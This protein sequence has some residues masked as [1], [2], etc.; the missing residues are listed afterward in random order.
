[1]IGIAQLLMA[2]D[3]PALGVITGQLEIAHVLADRA[4]AMRDRLG[5]SAAWPSSY[6]RSILAAAEGNVS[7]ARSLL[8]VART[9]EESCRV[10][11]TRADFLLVPAMAAA[12]DGRFA[13]CAGL[14]EVVRSNP[15]A[16]LSG[17]HF[18]I[19]RHLRDLAKAAL[20]PDEL[21]AAREAGRQIDT[22]TALADF[23]HPTQHA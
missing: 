18:A 15:I 12:H 16:L 23:L 3:N 2:G 19:A 10:G 4:D 20:E 11:P 13:D 7:E 14:L 22:D 9:S 1:M 21:A 8:E 17:T 6:S 5:V